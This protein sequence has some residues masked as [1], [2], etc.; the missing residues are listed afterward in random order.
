MTAPLADRMRALADLIA[1]HDLPEPAHLLL[2]PKR[3]RA[4]FDTFDDLNAWAGAQDA[5]ITVQHVRSGAPFIAWD[6]ELTVPGWTAFTVSW[7]EDVAA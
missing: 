5:R 3:G 7:H 2:G 1:Q 6:A 4:F